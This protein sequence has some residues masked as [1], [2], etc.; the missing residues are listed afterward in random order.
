VPQLVTVVL[1]LVSQPFETFPSQLPNP[2]VHAMEQLPLE[3]DA[4]PFALEHEAPH[5]PQFVRLELRLVSQPFAALPSQ[6]PKPALQAVSW[7]VPVAQEAEAFVKLHVVPQAP[8]DD[9]VLRLVSQPSVGSPLQFANP[10]AQ[11]GVHVPP[12][13]LVEP[14][15]LVHV[16][17]Q[18]PQ[19][20][21]LVLR[22][23]S[24]PFEAL[25]SQFP[26]PGLHD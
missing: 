2:A 15:A 22:F 18:V 7:Q 10:E 5:A 26:N 24:Q 1:R 16:R 23:A 3:H 4:V 6:L 20:D 13:Q 14:F 12:V 21:V 8:Q 19:F 25:P 11:V 9:R 17:Q